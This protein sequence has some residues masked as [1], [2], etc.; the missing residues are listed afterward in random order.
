MTVPWYFTA[1]ACILCG[2][3]CIKIVVLVHGKGFFVNADGSF[4]AAAAMFCFLAWPLFAFICVLTVLFR[5]V[6]ALSKLVAGYRPLPPEL[7]PEE[8]RL[9]KDG[10]IDT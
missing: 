1:V 3:A 4:D 7:T 5:A 2:F 10:N 6:T 8:R 9:L